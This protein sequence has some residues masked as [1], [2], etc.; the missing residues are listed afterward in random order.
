MRLLCLNP[1]TAP[2]SCTNTASTREHDPGGRREAQFHNAKATSVSQMESLL[3]RDWRGVGLKQ[4]QTPAGP[5]D[6]ADIA[7]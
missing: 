4:H 2:R 5:H 6:C 1:L 3:P 7:I